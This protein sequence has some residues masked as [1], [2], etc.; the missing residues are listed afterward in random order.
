MVAR[1]LIPRPV[2]VRGWDGEPS[3]MAE[4]LAELLED[5][6]RDFASRAVVASVVRGPVVLKA[7]G[8]DV[9]VGLVF[10][11]SSVEVVDGPVEDAPEVVGDWSTLAAVCSGRRSPLA[12]LAR[13]EL[14]LRGVRHVLRSAA[15]GFVLSV[16]RSF[17]EPDATRERYLTLALL[18]VAALLVAGAS[19][20]A[21]R[22]AAVPTS[23]GG[24]ES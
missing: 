16:P 8:R 24:V 17:Y 5:N 2:V 10:E 12:A 22:R 9:S 6:L 14:E 3:G 20:R 11:G 23:D 19:R 18:L 1:D 4:M 15:C 7:A 21:G 13:G